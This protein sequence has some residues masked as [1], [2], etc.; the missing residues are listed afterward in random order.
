M[1]LCVRS[2]VLTR[3]N[4]CFIGLLNC[5]DI[6]ILFGFSFYI[7]KIVDLLV[8]SW[9]SALTFPEMCVQLYIIDVRQDR[10]YK[11]QVMN[12]PLDKNDKFYNCRHNVSFVCVH[13]I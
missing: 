10:G 8:K 3:S 4:D 11:L 1:Y 2:I 9:W 12:L 5:F 13:D 6:A 7:V